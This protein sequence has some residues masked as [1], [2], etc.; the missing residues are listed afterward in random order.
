M[1]RH[2]GF[3]GSASITSSPSTPAKGSFPTR[4]FV[5]SRAAST[6][7]IAATTL[8]SAAPRF[9]RSEVPKYAPLNWGR[10]GTRA[11]RIQEWGSYL[12]G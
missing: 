6:S 4:S 10:A 9:R 7:P 5:T 11:S 1:G 2:V 8:M 12:A 3:G